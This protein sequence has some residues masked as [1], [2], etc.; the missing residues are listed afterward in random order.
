VTVRRD[1]I[2]EKTRLPKFR[3]PFAL[4]LVITLALQIAPSSAASPSWWTLSSASIAGVSISPP[5]ESK[6]A[7]TV[8]EITDFTTFDMTYAEA[9][10]GATS[11][12]DFQPSFTNS[13][14]VFSIVKFA[15]SAYI[16]DS[17]FTNSTSFTTQP[18]VN[19]DIFIVKVDIGPDIG[20]ER[21]RYYKLI[22]NVAA[23]SDT[24]PPSFTSSSSFSVVENFAT[25]SNAAT[26]TV[27]EN[28]TLTIS[29][30]SD[31]SLFDIYFSDNVTAF[32]KFKTSPN[33][34]APG[35]SGGN[36]IYD[37]TITA[38]DLVGNTNTQSITIAVTDVVE[39]SSFN[40]FALAGSATGAT[41]RT[42]I[43]ITANVSVASKVT[44]KARN[45]I[46]P[47][48]KN[49]MT[50]GSGSSFSVTCSWQPSTRGV[51]VLTASAVPTGADMSS[52]S[53]P[54]LSVFVGNRS[55]TRQ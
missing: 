1:D 25:S 9:N 7:A 49:K 36:N 42:S 29:S 48:C 32:I 47:S 51:V 16:D 19:G 2:L 34:E 26:I 30:G 53:A 10:S 27:S 6:A 23:G 43:V 22:A 11:G 12:G 44:F 38:A 39:A 4:L 15:S 20:F 41:Y 5:S 50:T 45:V 31:A 46:I 8:S 33:F 14:W 3:F 35:D 55:G 52:S 24:T 28:S 40:S 17:A 21:V 13:N 54:P 37:L 18:V